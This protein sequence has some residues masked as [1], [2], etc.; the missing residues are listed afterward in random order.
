MI[1]ISRQVVRFAHV[2]AAGIV[3]YPRYFEMLNAAVEDYFAEQIG[4]D[5]AQIHMARKL[6]IP[7][8]RLEADFTAPSRLGDRLDFRLNPAHVGRSSVKLSIDV[9]CEDEMRFRA[10]VVLVCVDLTSGKS[11]PW[12]A[13]MRPRAVETIDES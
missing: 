4:V 9:A 10:S 2:D 1:F 7:T 8:V 11:V 5:F 12:P 13:D 6:G 3:F